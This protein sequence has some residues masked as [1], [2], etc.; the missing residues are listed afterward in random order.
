MTD[1][2]A[3]SALEV[4]DAGDLPLPAASGDSGDKRTSAAGAVDTTKLVDELAPLLAKKLVSDEGFIRASQSIK[5]RRLK[6]LDKIKAQMERFNAYL[7][8]AGGDKDRAARDILVD[9]RLIG[10]ESTDAEEHPGKAAPA[11]AA[12]R[13]DPRAEVSDIL[14]KAGVVHSDEGYLKIVEAYKGQGITEEFMAEVR[15]Y[16]RIN[17]RNA[18]REVSAAVVAGEGGQAASSSS[19]GLE[20]QYI[21]K[22]RAARGNREA[23]RSLRSEY[24]AKGVDVNKALT[25][26]DPSR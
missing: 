11:S 15:A 13:P 20:Q 8:K 24:E 21:T 10:G 23:I 14:D 18:P 25:G 17:A 2:T 26:V 7:E 1:Q 22:L 4:P 3:E 5:D 16:A 12:V 19:S 9:E 6:D